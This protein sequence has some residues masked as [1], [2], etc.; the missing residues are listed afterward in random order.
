MIIVLRPGGMLQSDVGTVSG[1]DALAE[2]YAS[3]EI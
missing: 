2:E 3:L 1:I